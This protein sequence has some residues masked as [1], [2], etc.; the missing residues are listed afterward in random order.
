MG[1]SFWPSVTGVTPVTGVSGVSGVTGFFCSASPSPSLSLSLSLG[2]SLGTRRGP[3]QI[4]IA[5]V[6]DLAAGEHPLQ[7]E[8]DRAHGRRQARRELFGG[9]RLPG[10]GE[11][12]QDLTTL[13]GDAPGLALAQD[14]P[15]AI[16]EPQAEFLRFNLAADHLEQGIRS[17]RHPVQTPERVTTPGQPH[18]A[19]DAIAEVFGLTFV[20]LYG[21]RE[22]L[23][24]GDGL[25]A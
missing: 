15:E 22:Q 4:A 2:I 13:F 9:E 21:L 25:R 17:A 8:A 6:E 10:L 23:S 19:I 7:A 18:R 5:I 20:A 11:G 3:G 16:V 1:V 12:V 14:R 24:G